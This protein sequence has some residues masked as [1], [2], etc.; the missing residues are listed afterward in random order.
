MRLRWVAMFVLG[1]TLL[2]STLSIIRNE[3]GEVDPGYFS[4]SVEVTR[5]TEEP[6]SVTVMNRDNENKETL[7]LAGESSSGASR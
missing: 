6:D 1:S 4:L 3:A 2:L 7:M 5:M